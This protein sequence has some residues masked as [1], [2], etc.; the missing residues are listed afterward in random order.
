MKDILFMTHLDDKF[1]DG[2]LVMIYSMKKNVRDFM[3][4]P[5]KILH[6]SAISD[7][8]LDNVASIPVCAV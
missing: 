2:A 7:L 1:I 4:Y 5:M 8:S 3:D 6:S